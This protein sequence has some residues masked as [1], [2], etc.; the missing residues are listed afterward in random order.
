[1]FPAKTVIVKLLFKEKISATWFFNFCHISFFLNFI[2]FHLIFVYL[3][4]KLKINQPQQTF[5]SK[6]DSNSLVGFVNSNKTLN[7]EVEVNKILFVFDITNKITLNGHQ[8]VPRST[9]CLFWNKKTSKL[10]RKWYSFG[11]ASIK[12]GKTWPNI[13]PKCWT[14]EFKF[15]CLI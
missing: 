7:I 6:N 12:N 13:L 8:M 3:K 1:M 5:L 15:E 10:N 4:K 9:F 14:F 2:K 11:W